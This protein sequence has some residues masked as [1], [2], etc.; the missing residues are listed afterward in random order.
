MKR[1]LVFLLTI[2]FA[3][4][5]LPV[6][7]SGAESTTVFISPE[8]FRNHL[9]TWNIFDRDG[10]SFGKVIK[11]TNTK[12]PP[13]E[14]AITT[15][16]LPSDGEYYVYAR[17]RDYVSSDPNILTGVRKYQIA[18]G[19]ITLDKVLGA[20]GNNGWEWELTGTLSLESGNVKNAGNHHN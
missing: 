12:N 7:S 14:S 2:C 20:H 6:I 3:I 10:S 11:A 15:I 1:L 17:S 4:S 19:G 13:G 8:A 18:V 16:S 5:T 9:G